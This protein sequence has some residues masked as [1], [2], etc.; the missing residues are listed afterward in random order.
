MAYS[1]RGYLNASVI[2]LLMAVFFVAA[3]ASAHE[4]KKQPAKP[5]APFATWLEA[6]KKE[7]AG[8]GISSQT[9]KA[10]FA[11]VKP[12]PR[13]IELD[14]RQPEF[15][16]TFSDYLSRVVPKKRRD[17]GRA[18]LAENR[19]LLEEVAAKYGVQPRFIVAF[20]GIETDFGRVTGG[21]PVIASLAT[22]AHDGR[23][24]AFFRRQLMHALNIIDQGHITPAKMVG[25]WAGAMGQCQFMPSSFV[26]FA[27]DHDGDGRR[28]IWGTRAD[29][30]ASAANYLSGSG[31]RGDQTWGRKVRLP[32]DFDLSVAD[33]KKRKPISQWQA[34]GVRNMDGGDLPA[35]KLQA[36]LVLPDDGNRAPA[37]MVYGNY[38]AILKWNRSHFFAIAVGTLSDA[39][40][41]GQ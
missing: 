31:W 25:S 41:K 21:F 20:W 8:K 32:K 6:L 27:Q 2:P 16:L 19:A 1:P 30:F 11:G 14:R 26:N 35:R 15:T 22:L 18:K 34:M 28:D 24:S 4:T 23:R 9:I 7:A 39:I 12:I 40:V 13:V 3:T 37:Y 10:A 17:K 29:V 38:E 5:A 33:G 36:A